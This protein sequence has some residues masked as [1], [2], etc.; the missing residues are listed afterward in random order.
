[1]AAQPALPALWRSLRDQAYRAYSGE[2]AAK[3][4]LD[5]KRETSS[6][7]ASLID[8]ELGLCAA[9]FPSDI[10]QVVVE[11]VNQHVRVVEILLARYVDRLLAMNV[12]AQGLLLS[13][14]EPDSKRRHVNTIVFGEEFER[15]LGTSLD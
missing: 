5:L 1:M 6:L 8:R 14:G 9:M 12:A 2:N 13:R 7:R 3:H 4:T 15:V 11:F 10:S